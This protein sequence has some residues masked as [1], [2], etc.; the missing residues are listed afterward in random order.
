MPETSKPLIAVAGATSKQGRSVVT[1]LLESGRYRVRALTRNPDSAQARG[2]AG[3]GAEITEVPLA[4]GHQ[5]EFVNAFAS[6]DGAFLM[7]PP[8]LPPDSEEYPLGRE[9]ADAAVE[10]GVGHVVFSTLE[11]VEERTSGRKWAPHF[12]DKALVAEYIRTLPVAHTFV[13]L[14]FYYTNMLEY[15]APRVEGDTV[16]MPFYLPE[17]FRAPFV[18]PLTAAGPAV[19][20]VFSN[21]DTYLGAWLPVVGDLI[22]PAEMVEAFSRVTGLK[23]E[24][25][26][27]YTRE[28]LLNYFPVFAENS[29]FA[30]ETIGMVEYAVEFGYFR[31]DRDIQWSRRIDPEALTWEQFVRNADWRGEPV[32]FGS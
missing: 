23:A 26:N 7:T 13:S 12:T 6:A 4:L 27:A 25:R 18:D 1:S 14:S 3:M 19:L 28:G 17:D 20:E 10:A 8:L 15:Y 32:A 9:L 31:D 22:S 16:I 21:P 11:N 24:Y 29:F 30:N 5:R 2:L